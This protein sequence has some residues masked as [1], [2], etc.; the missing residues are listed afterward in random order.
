M[1]LETMTGQLGDV[2][3]RATTQLG[4]LRAQDRKSRDLKL[5]IEE[6]ENKLCEAI[7]TAQ[8]EVGYDFD[9]AP[10]VAKAQVRSAAGFV[11]ICAFFL[12]VGGALC[13]VTC[14]QSLPRPCPPLPFAFPAQ[15][16]MQRRAA[17][18]QLLEEKGK[19][20]QGLYDAIDAK[21]EMFDERTQ[22]IQVR[23]MRRPQVC[24]AG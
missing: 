15:E 9:E 14:T 2:P 21:I 13:Y 1:W 3:A 6:E 16:L 11:Y 7:K 8:A 12:Y 19:L 20:A 17:L 22:S 24:M 18:V 5:L 4:E 23:R 10:F